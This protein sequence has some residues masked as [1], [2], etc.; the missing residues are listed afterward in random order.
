MNILVVTHISKG[1]NT[2]KS[3][4][5]GDRG[6]AGGYNS[7]NVGYTIDC[8]C[9]VFAVFVPEMWVMTRNEFRG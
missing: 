4:G 9:W 5:F 3:E 1:Q 8:F 7:S 6:P 2:L